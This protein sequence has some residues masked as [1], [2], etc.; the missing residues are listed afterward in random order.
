MFIQLLYA[1][2]YIIILLINFFSIFIFKYYNDYYLYLD[3]TCNDYSI[4]L[5]KYRYNI[6][7][8]N[9]DYYK[10]IF[11]SSFWIFILILSAI[12]ISIFFSNNIYL[13]ITFI[14]FIIIYILISY[15]IFNIYSLD[16]NDIKNYKSFY[17][18]LN[19]VV[20][21]IINK[22]T[23]KH[24]RIE[25]I[26]KKSKDNTNYNIVHNEFN[27]TI[28]I[29][30]T[31]LNNVYLF[32]IK[33]NDSLNTI[34]YI[35]SV[36]NILSHIEPQQEAVEHA[37]A[38]A[39][40]KN[41]YN[42]IILE[43]NININSIVS[44]SLNNLSVKYI[45]YRKSDNIYKS[46]LFYN[47]TTSSSSKY[48]IKYYNENGY[49]TYNIDD[50]DRKINV[51]NTIGYTSYTIFD[52][53]L[54]DKQH[55]DYTIN[56]I[57]FKNMLRNMITKYEN[58]GN[59]ADIENFLEKIY[60]N[61]FLKYFVLNNNYIDTLDIND[62]LYVFYKYYLDIDNL[63]IDIDIADKAVLE[64]YN[65][66]TNKLVIDKTNKINIK[67]LSDIIEKKKIIVGDDARNTKYN[68][69]NKY[70]DK[71]V[72]DDNGIDN[73]KDIFS[74]KNIIFTDSKY[75]YKNIKNYVDNNLFYLYILIIIYIYFLII[76]LHILLIIFNINYI[77][78]IVS[79]ILTLFIIFKLYE[80]INR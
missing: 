49:E 69:I 35:K 10:N 65:Y 5:Y 52:K 74:Y 60:N 66:D 6:G 71:L 11:I 12:S 78:I 70:Y 58:I 18:N 26:S 17:K 76:V 34:F 51:D 59:K 14:T 32:I 3:K 73:L 56:T 25:T 72:N 62:D 7:K 64:S 8:I 40:F 77:Y 4:E 57:I 1:F 22:E 43:N 19:G 79:L 20:K 47:N 29:T 42:L 41:N 23:R 38:G 75:L 53:S 2:M 30:N 67:V 21:Y 45:I 16:T 63:Y 61:D 33:I 37:E 28:T 39:F 15:K 48:I 46:D 36:N 68:L 54:N 50:N 24:Y 80:I 55:N 13:I 44:G 9:L 31:D 27:S